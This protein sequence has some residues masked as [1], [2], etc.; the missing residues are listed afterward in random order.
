MKFWSNRAVKRPHV[1]LR[2]RTPSSPAHRV[3]DLGHVVPSPPAPN[4]IRQARFIP[5]ILRVKLRGD[6]IFHL[7]SV[8][9]LVVSGALPWLGGRSEPSGSVPHSPASYSLPFLPLPLPPL[10]RPC[11]G[12][13]PR[14]LTAMNETSRVAL[15]SQSGDAERI[16]LWCFRKKNPPGLK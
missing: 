1:G 8:I 3:Q 5:P 12:F 13:A 10:W 6:V 14:P 11:A 15:S 7:G 4:H 16:D 9:I 2:S